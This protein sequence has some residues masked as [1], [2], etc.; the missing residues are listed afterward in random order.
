MEDIEQFE[1]AAAPLIA[2]AER[3]SI[4]ECLLVK[5]PANRPPWTSSGIR[6]SAGDR[7]SVF[8]A[9]RATIA[10]APDIWV[11]AHFTLWMRIDSSGEI[12]RTPSGGSYTFTAGQSGE[13]FLGSL[14]PG[15]WADRSGALSTDSRA[16]ERVAGTIAVLIVLWNAEPLTG[17]ERLAGAHPAAATILHAEAARLRNPPITPPGWHYMWSIGN[18][19]IFDSQR[20]AAREPLMKCCVRDDAAIM[21]RPMHAALD[22]T[23]RLRWRWKIDA[24]PSTKREDTVPSH[25]YLSVAVEFD[26][27]QDLT[28]LWSA[29]LDPGTAFRCPIPRWS[30]RETHMVIR[31]GQA[32]LGDWVSEERNI[33]EDYSRAIGSPL[34]AIVAVW[35]IAVGIFSHTTGQ[36]EYSGLELVTANRTVALI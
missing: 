27:G 3:D 4:A 2:R 17:L 21:Q 19:G 11:G 7:V 1:A 22:D 29:A 28:Y 31:S 12:F 36:C 20:S 18:S 24:L 35:L 5:I 34:A 15:D 32:G 6:L 10:A 16:Y 13:L 33:R 25:D 23:A 14:F 9:G 8:L 30:K 26:N